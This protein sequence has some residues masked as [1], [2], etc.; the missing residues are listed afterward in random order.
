MNGIMG[1]AKLLADTRLSPEQ[2]TY[3][4]AVSTSASA[5]LALIEDLLDYS[6]IEAGRF[7]LE[8]QPVSMR[9]IADSIVELLSARAYAKGIG[10]GC[11]VA[12]DV[13]LDR[14]GRSGPVAPGAA[15]SHRQRHQVHRQ[16]RRAGRGRA[17]PG[18]EA[19]PA[20]RFS[21]TDTG[22]GIPPGDLERIFEEFEQADGT[23]T[24]QHGGAGL[25][26]AISRRIVTSMGGTIGVASELG[27][28]STFH[29]EIPAS[30]ARQCG[31]K[32]RRHA[33][34][35]PRRHPVEEHASRPRRSPARSPPTAARPKSP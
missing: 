13:P 26:L 20:I 27:V 35:P 21:V 8:P 2:R 17:T 11:H 25:G 10:L 1:M 4:G 3:V 30:D 32:R 34:R 7:E 29:F 31:R 33:G 19:A 22:P 6:K 15:Q 24:R 28:G 16:R 18:S 14:H 12:P 23:S 5:L 9:E